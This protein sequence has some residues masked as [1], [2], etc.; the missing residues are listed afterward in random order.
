MKLLSS[1]VVCAVSLVMVHGKVSNSVASLKAKVLT[2][3]AQVR[4]ATSLFS[5]EEESKELRFKVSTEG[6][7]MPI[8]E[9]L[10]RESWTQVPDAA[11]PLMS[12]GLDMM[13]PTKDGV[14][15]K[16][17][18][19][20][21][22]DAALNCKSNRVEGD[23]ASK[24]LSFVFSCDNAGD[25]SSEPDKS[26]F[27]EKVNV[28]GCASAASYFWQ[29]SYGGCPYGFNNYDWGSWSYPYFSVGAMGVYGCD[30]LSSCGYCNSS[31]YIYPFSP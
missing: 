26:R 21:S 11:F 19:E 22:D 18:K 31:P 5:F 17:S 28:A 23:R 29:P 7:T 8:P 14:S 16:S 20:S 10:Q 2:E 30:G 25:A 9:F 24:T 4:A 27:A 12:K 15:F 3:K 13:K 6:V 1:L